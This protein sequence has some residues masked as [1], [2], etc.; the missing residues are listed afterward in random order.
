MK[1][2]R[3]EWLRLQREYPAIENSKLSME[4]LMEDLRDYN[5]S[6][7][8]QDRAYRYLNQKELE[9]QKSKEVWMWVARSV[10]FVTSV[11][12]IAYAFLGGLI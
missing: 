5:I 1:D 8:A 10:V 2:L 11:T 3:N 12:Y 4:D 6:K 9:R 7:E